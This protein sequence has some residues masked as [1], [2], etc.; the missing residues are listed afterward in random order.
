MA[1]TKVPKK[2][3]AMITAERKRQE[4]ELRERDA[5]AAREKAAM[6]EKGRQLYEAHYEQA[7]QKVPEWLR[8]Y[9]VPVSTER[10]DEED[11]E[12]TGRGWGRVDGSRLTFN[13]PGLAP[14]SFDPEK[15]MFMSACAS[16]NSYEDTQPQ[17]NYRNSEW[18]ENLSAILLQA[19]REAQKLAEQQAEYERVQVT[20]KEF[21]EEAEARQLKIDAAHAL[22]AQKE[23]SEAEALIAALEEDQ[24]AIFL[25]KAFLVLRRERQAYE[26]QIDGMEDSLGYAEEFWSRKAAS[27]R[28]QAE[29]AE[30]RAEDERRRANDAQDDLDKANKKIKSIEQGW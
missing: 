4:A 18:K 1:T 11:L 20:Q 7:L 26:R 13:I 8:Q 14:I 3:A 6:V 28:R 10:T 15:A 5:A 23:R 30:S 19:E 24:V 21:I 25:L 17:F 2:V 16:W 22:E 27:L 29:D 9:V 12:R